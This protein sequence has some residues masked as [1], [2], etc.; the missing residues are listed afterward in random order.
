MNECIEWEGCR[1]NYG[2]GWRTINGRNAYAHRAAYCEA[3]GLSLDDIK[4]KVVR[5]RCD[6]PA[7]VNPDHLELGTQGDNLTD[8]AKR[9][10]STAGSRHGMSKLTDEQVAWVRMACVKGCPVNGIAAWAR[11]LGVASATVSRLV[12]EKSWRSGS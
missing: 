9:G 5:H 11:R 8:M 4:G 7:C 1:K 6:N 12:N 2:Y 10:R 3:H